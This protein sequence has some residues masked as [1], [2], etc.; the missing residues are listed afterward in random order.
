[1]YIYIQYIYNYICYINKLSTWIAPFIWQLCGI[2]ISWSSELGPVCCMPNW[3]AES[4]GIPLKRRGRDATTQPNH[5]GRCC[6]SGAQWHPVTST[7]SMAFGC[8]AVS[9]FLLQQSSRV[10]TDPM[11]REKQSTPTSCDIDIDW[12]FHPVWTECPLESFTGG[13]LQCGGWD[14]GCL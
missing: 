3:A 5:R 9:V 2:R 6:K 11:E 1:M 7:W 10:N 12:N 4:G 8:L 14:G 13:R